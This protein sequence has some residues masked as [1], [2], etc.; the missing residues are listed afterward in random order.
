MG[1]IY[2]NSNRDNQFDQFDQNFSLLDFEGGYRVKVGEMGH[3]QKEYL[4]KIFSS[5]YPIN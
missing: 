3:C 4:P 5:I 2:F 1:I